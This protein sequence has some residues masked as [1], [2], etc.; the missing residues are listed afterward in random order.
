MGRHSP[1]SIA[2][3]NRGGARRQ[4]AD[5]RRP[6]HHRQ[7]RQPIGQRH[8]DGCDVERC[9]HCGWQALGCAH[10]HADDRRRQVWTGRWPSEEDCERLGLFVN[11]SRA[12]RSES[13]VHRV[14]LGCR[15]RPVGAKAVSE[16]C[17]LRDRAIACRTNSTP[18]I[19]PM[20]QANTA[21]VRASSTKTSPAKDNAFGGGVS[22][23]SALP[24]ATPNSLGCSGHS[25]CQKTLLASMSA[26]CVQ[27][28][29]KQHAAAIRQD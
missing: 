23:E 1:L 24:K 29:A 7:H 9:P 15:P 22:P 2:R 16:I 18:T 27:G 25:S 10:F 5:P 6:A 8:R 14:C 4:V 11:E 17:Q 26:A 21:R 13:L 19:P 28:G 20:I 3:M 12:S